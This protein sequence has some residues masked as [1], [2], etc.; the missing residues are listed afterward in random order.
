MSMLDF[1]KNAGYSVASILICIVIILSYIF[2]KNEKKIEEKNMCFI[3]YLVSII[4]MSFAEVLYV[5]YF[6]KY[7][8]D[9]KYINLFYY[10]YSFSILFAVFSAWRFVIVY[11]E[12]IHTQRKNNKFKKIAYLINITFEVLMLI[13]IFVLPVKIQSNYGI[14]TFESLPITIVLVYSFISTILFLFLVYY[15]NDRITKN[16]LIPAITSIILILA[17]LLFRLFIKIDINIET[18]QLT[19]FALGLFFT[20]ENQDSLLLIKS[21]EKQS[22][23][24]KAN[25]SQKDFLSNISHKIRSPLNII[26]GLSQLLNESDALQ[27]ESAMNDMETIDEAADSLLVLISNLTD[28]SS[29]IT[30]KEEVLIEEY[31]IDELFNE[32]YYNILAKVKKNINIIYNINGLFPRKLSGDISKIEKIVLNILFDEINNSN[33]NQIIINVVG[34]QKENNIFNITFSIITT[35]YSIDNK[36]FNINDEDFNIKEFDKLI[37]NDILGLLIA[38]HYSLMLNGNLSFTNEDRVKTQYVFSI[39]EK[40]IDNSLAQININKII[41]TSNIRLDLSNKKALI[42]YDN[43]NDRIEIKK[44]LNKYNMQVDI[45]NISNEV[46]N[47]V[48]NNKY[49]LIIIDYVMG[50]TN[51]VQI[52]NQIKNLTPYVPPIITLVSDSNNSELNNYNN[53]IFYDCLILPLN[54]YDLIK[55]L[56]KL[57]YMEGGNINA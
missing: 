6:L 22:A 51:A 37:N 9:S 7:G 16:D 15:K 14:Y 8:I 56:Y 35:N 19:L 46:A 55:L 5:L 12:T 21:K 30:N 50:N 28:Y 20:V 25:L 43:S 53:N 10:L 17:L 27:S 42:V 1:F 52:Y 26:Y 31:N 11:N 2:K 24:Q 44:L 29:I 38:K 23:A 3:L 41:N 54:Y 33:S 34:N 49:D 36:D 45:C 18:F 13:L 57:F 47:I 32:I 4:I 39:D 40:V 48:C